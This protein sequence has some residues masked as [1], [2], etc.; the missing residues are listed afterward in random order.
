MSEILYEIVGLLVLIVSNGVFAM[1]EI[2]VV[3][4]RRARLQEMAERGHRGA[5]A[6][7]DL[8]N[9]PGA[10]L[11]T[12]QIGIT[13]V[14]ILAGAFAGAT[15]ARVLAEA[16]SAIAW[17]R[18]HADQVAF[19]VTIAMIT[20]LSLIVGELVPK[21]ISIGNP[22]RIASVI[23]PPMLFLSR[24]AH[25]IVKFLN[26]STEALL[27]VIRVK[28][29]RESPITLDELR[30]LV[31][32][33]N[34][35]GVLEK[36]E[37]EMMTNVLD[38]GDRNAASL[39]TRRS[40]VVYLDT[41]DPIEETWRKI[42]DSGHTH[43]PLCSGNH[44]EILGIVPVD[45]IAGHPDVHSSEDLRPHAIPVQY[46]PET[47]RAIQVLEAFRTSRK[48][49]AVVIDEYGCPQGIIT[50]ADLLK[51]LVGPLPETERSQENS[52]FHRPDGS[53]LL[54]GLVSVLQFRA[55]FKTGPLPHQ[56][57]GGFGTLGGFVTTYLS[58]IPRT[59][60][61]FD[62]GGYRFEVVDMDDNRVDKILL[63]PLATGHAQSRKS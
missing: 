40:E 32:Q 38:F 35:A 56:K 28:P 3:S 10:F 14:G 50:L 19:G 1:S 23:A 57:S 26:Y 18:P 8:V 34:A 29:S 4:S 36:S 59:G 52:I 20:Y 9:D 46:V 7:L 24:I 43:F 31:K 5:K 25:P 27:W 45:S 44:D 61:S 21:R 51:A 60:D 33:A 15:V 37:H 54:D 62:W 63:T 30:I 39:M 47:T 55:H 22:E 58:R 48:H 49:I 41:R 11:A 2:A 42:R 53:W 13:L 12:V 6:A 16:L 17:L